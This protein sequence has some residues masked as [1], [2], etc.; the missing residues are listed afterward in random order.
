[1]ETKSQTFEQKIQFIIADRCAAREAAKSRVLELKQAAREHRE[2][3]EQLKQDAEIAEKQIVEKLLE[4]KPV[5]A[6]QAKVEKLKKD[7]EHCISWSKKLDSELIP[8][9]ESEINHLQNQ[10]NTAV[11]AAIREEINE[12]SKTAAEAFSG[13]ITIC[14]QW[15]ADCLDIVR[16]TGAQDVRP[17]N[18]HRLKVMDAIKTIPRSK[19]P[20]AKKY[21]DEVCRD[22][23]LV[24]WL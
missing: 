14:E 7:A 4:G 2:K 9:I 12:R 22:F 23:S 1:M 15:E 16:R 8:K 11:Q 5:A 17:H 20:N 6:L 18:Q 10:V 19:R 13:L 21:I 24:K 3:S